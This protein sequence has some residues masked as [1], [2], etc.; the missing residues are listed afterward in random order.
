[1]Q[2][3]SSTTSAMFVMQAQFHPT[4]SVCRAFLPQG[5]D[6]VVRFHLTGFWGNRFCPVSYILF[7][8]TSSEPLPCRH[9]WRRTMPPCPEAP[10]AASTETLNNW[11]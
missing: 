7:E 9:A 8:P 4:C 2:L 10:V 11:S 5:E 6:G 1:M 3:D